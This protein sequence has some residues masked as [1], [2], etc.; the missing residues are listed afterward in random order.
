M[1][2]NI[3][4]Q[5]Y[6]QLKDE[7]D[8]QPPSSNNIPTKQATYPKPTKFDPLAVPANLE[9]AEDHFKA[10]RIAR[11][12]RSYQKNIDP[13][14]GLPVDNTLVSV[15]C[16]L[17]ELNFL[18][19]GYSLYYVFL[20]YLA[21]TSLMLFL[22][23]CAYSMWNNSKGGICYELDAIPDEIVDNYDLLKQNC[24]L[25]FATKYSLA[26][27]HL[28]GT[29]LEKQEIFN[30]FTIGILLVLVHYLRK[31]LK[32]TAAVCDGKSVTVSDFTVRFKNF[33]RD[34]DKGAD[35]HEEVKKF[36]KTEALPGVQLDVQNIHLCSQV[37]EKEKLIRKLKDI[38]AKREKILVRHE[39][40]KVLP[41]DAQTLDKL[42]N[43]YVS[44]KA[45]VD[46]LS[47]KLK[48]GDQLKELYT[49]EGF[50]T[51]DSQ[52]QVQ[53][54]LAHWN[55][56]FFGRL[57]EWL[58]SES[59]HKYRGNLIEIT[60]ASEPSDILW[61][62]VGTPA[63]SLFL[64]RVIAF[65]LS[66]GFLIGFGAVVFII[67]GEKSATL[68]ALETETDEDGIPIENSD[69]ITF[70]TGVC[71][72]FIVVVNYLLRFIISLLVDFSKYPTST[73]AL[74]TYSEYLAWS[75][76]FNTAIVTTLIAISFENIWGPGGLVTTIFQIHL[77]I[78]LIGW[79]VDCLDAKYLFRYIQ[80]NSIR[81]K[82]AR[83]EKIILTQEELNSIFEHPEFDFA[84]KYAFYIKTLL[85]GAFFAPIVPAVIP[86]VTVT[87]AVGYWIDKYL[88]LRKR[89]RTVAYGSELPLHL[90]KFL[91]YVILTFAVGNVYFHTMVID[92]T[93][94]DVIISYLGLFLAL[95]N[96]F[97]PVDKIVSFIVPEG[98]QAIVEV[99]YSEKKDFFNEDYAR[100][101]PAI[102]ASEIATFVRKREGGVVIPENPQPQLNF[103]DSQKNQFEVEANK[104]Q[105]LNVS[106]NNP[107]E[108][109]ANKSEQQNNSNYPPADQ[110]QHNLDNQEQI[111]KSQQDLSQHQ[112]PQYSN[113][114]E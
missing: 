21:Y 100:F 97:L 105:N 98:E 64:R 110:S 9:F 99:T 29:S 39:D 26:N 12:K 72:A 106:Q 36:F 37:S 102:K 44:I 8:G 73:D 96:S 24:I 3:E 86:I 108:A 15:C 6:A 54:L 57:R 80:R 7:V 53:K 67:N 28:N 25:S 38:V 89:A 5:K 27:N 42:E 111:E 78:T 40:G 66:V 88:M 19:T 75:Q 82:N 85:S 113:Y 51:L 81:S 18:P 109:E 41:N 79:L 35:L 43:E 74:K 62:N 101:N 63:I 16:D 2:D 94:D 32:Q 48:G 49:D 90:A 13:Q 33:P 69:E 104:S 93:T 4:L 52:R 107:F 47:E 77:L 65:I 20:K 30:L 55:I 68:E 92:F 71:S 1:N 50:V 83:G 59:I 31:A 46:S 56:G 60:T 103:N 58:K 84:I 14:S 34:F 61:E 87:I 76:F 114:E 23:S 11:E 95:G 45:E 17:D 10:T 112:P 70:I 22:T 91:E